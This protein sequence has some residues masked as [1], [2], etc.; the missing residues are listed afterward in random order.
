[1]IMYIYIYIPNFSHKSPSYGHPDQS[2]A[3]NSDGFFWATEMQRDPLWL[4]SPKRVLSM[5][6]EIVLVT[7]LGSCTNGCG[8]ML[9]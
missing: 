6:L 8:V 1:M 9:V 7:D 4:G 2:Q 3:I 5:A